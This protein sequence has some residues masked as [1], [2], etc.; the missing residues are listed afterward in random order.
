[1][2]E[3]A[4]ML[5]C[6]YAAQFPVAFR[7]TALSNAEADGIQAE[8]ERE[9]EAWVASRRRRPGLDRHAASRVQ[10]GVLEAYFSVDQR[11]HVDSILFAGDFIANSPAVETL[12]QR[13]RGCP[14]QGDAIDRIVSKVFE[15]KENFILGVGKLD[16]I[17]RLLAG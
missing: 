5:C 2:E 8:A 15:H 14:L 9:T 12:E 3:V 11:S 6:G 16:A 13:L 17:S 4:T 10:V 7:R 1:M